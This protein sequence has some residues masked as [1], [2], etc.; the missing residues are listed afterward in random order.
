[1]PNSKKVKSEQADSSCNASGFY[2]GAALLPLG[3]NNDCR[4]IFV[5]LLSASWQVWG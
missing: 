5:L 2:H 3:C 4:E 1:V